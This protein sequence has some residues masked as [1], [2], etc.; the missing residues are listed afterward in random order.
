[1]DDSIVF[2]EQDFKPNIFF[3][4]IP[5]LEQLVNEIVDK[6]KN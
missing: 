6:F 2:D 5:Q 4:P 3:T 1:M